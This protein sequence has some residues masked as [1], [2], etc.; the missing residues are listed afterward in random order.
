VQ[1]AADLVLRLV[2]SVVLRT[3]APAGIYAVAPV[4]DALVDLSP[5]HLV[6]VGDHRIVLTALRARSP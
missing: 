1:N 3:A 4:R 6:V 5:N 2:Q